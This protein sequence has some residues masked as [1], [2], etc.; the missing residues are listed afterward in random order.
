MLVCVCVWSTKEEDKAV[1]V[2]QYIIQIKLRM[3][4]KSTNK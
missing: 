2:L 1:E 3:G 4:K